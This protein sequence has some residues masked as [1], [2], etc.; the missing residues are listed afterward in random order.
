MLKEM[1]MGRPEPGISGYSTGIGR[2][3]KCYEISTAKADSKNCQFV[4][5]F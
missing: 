3:A 1:R 4:E 2:V 5:A